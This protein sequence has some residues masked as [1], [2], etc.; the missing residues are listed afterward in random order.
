MNN[1]KNLK[2]TEENTFF[3]I[4]GPCIIES[5]EE[6]LDIA[7]TLKTITD[8]LRIPF[9]FKGSFK[10]AN[11]T[12]LDSFTGIGDDKALEIL[13]NVKE[14]LRIPIITDV[15]SIEDVKKVAKIVDVIQIP[16]FL[17]RQ[18]EL[19]TSASL[20]GKH[21]N[22]KKGQFLSSENMRFAIEKIT[23]MGNNNV[24]LTERGSMYG[25]NDLIVDYRSIPIMKEFGHPVVL[26]I[27]HSLQKPNN[28]SGVSGGQPN[29]IET[30]AKAGIAVGVDG[31]F[32]E[33]H[34]NPKKSKSDG[35]NMIKLDLVENLLIKLKKIKNSI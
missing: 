32:L 34:M 26:D 28:A 18:T 20:T 14:T 12:R 33:T 11:R 10:K 17:C 30:I 23:S 5:E 21:V 9:I 2:Y 22:L 31:I 1:I 35:E 15:H 16:A 19:L 4:A 3:L 6:T 25:Y 8:K 7:K 27:T 29:L 13:K 24:I